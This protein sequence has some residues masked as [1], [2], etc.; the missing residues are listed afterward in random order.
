[1]APLFYDEFIHNSDMDKENTHMAGKDANEIT[2]DSMTG[3]KD[4]V[5]FFA[6]VRRSAAAGQGRHMV[7]IQLTQLMRINRKHGA[8][9]GDGKKGEIL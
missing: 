2:Y 4:R 5:T 6:D 3:L 1:M 9:V 7:L 8:T